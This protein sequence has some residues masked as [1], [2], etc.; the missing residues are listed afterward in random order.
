VVKGG[1]RNHCTKR[2]L[3]CF[4]FKKSWERRDIAGEWLHV[5]KIQIE[6]RTRAPRIGITMGNPWVIFSN[7]YLYPSKPVPKVTGTGSA[8]YR[9]GY[10][11][12]LPNVDRF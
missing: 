12:F 7:P 8:G 5:R 9:Y 2:L 11:G 3:Y 1:K 4:G 6:H 10:S